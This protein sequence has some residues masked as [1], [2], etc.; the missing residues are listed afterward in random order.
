MKIADY[1]QWG[2]WVCPPY[3]LNEFKLFE[4]PAE[5][6]EPIWV[7]VSVFLPALSVSD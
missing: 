4:E 1:G 6:N 7:N 3:E 2:I 5:K